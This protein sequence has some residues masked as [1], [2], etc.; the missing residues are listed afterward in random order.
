[1]KS[2]TKECIWGSYFLGPRSNE[3]EIE[4]WFL[5]NTP[6]LFRYLS[7]NVPLPI[8]YRSSAFR[9]AVDKPD[10]AYFFATVSSSEK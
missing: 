2:F 7:A 10:A 4:T 8:R 6:L 9:S 5:E 3:K 1:M